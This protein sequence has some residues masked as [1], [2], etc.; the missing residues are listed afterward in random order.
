LSVIQGLLLGIV[1]GLTEFLPVSSSGHLVVA[2]ALMGLEPNMTVALGVHAGTALSVLVL[3]SGEV[4]EIIMGF[5]RGIAKRDGSAKMAICLILTSIPAAL[6]GF[7]ASDA[8]EHAFG[9]PL[10][11]GIGFLISGVVLWCADCISSRQKQR[12]QESINE[13][14]IGYKQALG[15]GV[16]QA[17]AIFPGVSRSGLTIS[18]A[19]ALKFERGFATSYSFIASLPVI[20]G[21]LILWP[22]ANPGALAEV[23]LGTLLLAVAASFVSGLAA[24]I[25]LR[26]VVVRGK[27]TYFSY[28]LWAIGIITILLHA[29]GLL[30]L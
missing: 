25:F 5:F 28:Y 4:W 21:S 17:C 11:A 13:G 16:A 15:V 20:V 7:A 30:G 23:Q 12:K 27:L 26:R 2:Q 18:S 3:Y 24:M 9:S 6:V 19:L 22:V 14:N 1:Q 8:V 10:F 29:R